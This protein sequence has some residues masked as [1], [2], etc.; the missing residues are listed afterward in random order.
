M[1]DI[2]EIMIPTIDPIATNPWNKLAD[3]AVSAYPMLTGQWM[4]ACLRVHCSI[5]W[6][7]AD[8]LR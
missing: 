2:L 7:K 3:S 8:K 6:Q 4:I 5:T 1:R